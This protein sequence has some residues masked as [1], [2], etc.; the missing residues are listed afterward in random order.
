MRMILLVRF[1]Q[2][3][4]CKHI[5]HVAAWWVEAAVGGPICGRTLVATVYSEV[6]VVFAEVAVV[7]T[8]PE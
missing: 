3:L 2:R 6:V 7:E 4:L 5:F 1:L 8:E